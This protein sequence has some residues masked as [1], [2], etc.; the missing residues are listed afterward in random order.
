MKLQSIWK[1]VQILDLW[2]IM[3]QAQVKLSLKSW[4]LLASL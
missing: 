2:R 3:E 1:T 4:Q